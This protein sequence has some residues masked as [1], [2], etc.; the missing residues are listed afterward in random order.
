MKLTDEQKQLYSI[1][2][3]LINMSASEI[4]KFLDSDEGKAAGLSRQE[5][6]T[7]GAGGKK[8]KSGRD[9]AR[10][11]IRML[12]TKKEDWTENDWA[13]AK[14]Q[15]SFLKRM[16]GVKAPLMKDDKKT[17]KTLAL[18][19]WGHNPL[20]ESVDEIL[21]IIE[22]IEMTFE[23]ELEL[24][25]AEEEIESKREII[26]TDREIMWQKF[27]ELTNVTAADL[28][29]FLKS[30]AAKDVGWT[31]AEAEKESVNGQNYGQKEGEL[32]AGILSKT[33]KFRN[34]TK[35][36]DN[37]SDAE[38]NSIGRMCRFVSRFRV[39]PGDLKDSEGKP[40]PKYLAMYMRGH[41][42]SKYKK[43]VPST[44]EIKKELK[45]KLNESYRIANWLL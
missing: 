4:E 40:T 41:D 20:K 1:W 33:S 24:F 8:I 19:V 29:S 3:K 32:I 26:P 34:G 11:I 13:W 38:W 25:E 21:N 45:D 37:L 42:A 5:A 16:L 30:E 15:V 23:E 44:Q 17:R 27:V 43:S 2:K 6:R 39:L 18:M 31:K 7:A 28:R 9:S 36:P 12:E 22:D 14:R 35:A 10:A